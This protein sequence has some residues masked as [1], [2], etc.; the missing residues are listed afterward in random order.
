[1]LAAAFIM[2]FL[3]KKKKQYDKIDIEDGEKYDG[4]TDKRKAFLYAGFKV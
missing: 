1:M 4:R 2:L 3:L